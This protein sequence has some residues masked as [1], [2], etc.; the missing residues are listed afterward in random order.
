MPTYAYA[1]KDCGHSFDVQQSFSDDALTV[2]PECGGQL[3]KQF[4]AVGVVFK[5]SGF[6]KTDSRD[7]G[8]KKAS[9]AASSESSSGDKKS[10]DTKPAD[11]TSSS[12]S[13]TPAAS[14]PAD[15]KTGKGSAA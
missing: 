15:T 4:G 14:T 1:C 12:S 7:A 10:T 13:S 8:T 11:S 2:C 5:G 9:A 3:R 6:Y